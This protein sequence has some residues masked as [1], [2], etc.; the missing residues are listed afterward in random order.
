MSDTI[1]IIWHWD[2]PAQEQSH[3]TESLLRV[4]IVS[5]QSARK[6]VTKSILIL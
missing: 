5:A 4:A 1:E 3:S 2:A 6:S